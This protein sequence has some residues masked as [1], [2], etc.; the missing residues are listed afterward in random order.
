MEKYSKKFN[1]CNLNERIKRIL[2]N[3]QLKTNKIF[4]DLLLRSLKKI[5]FEKKIS[6]LKLKYKSN[7]EVKIKKVWK[8]TSFSIK[9]KL[10]FN[11]VI[12]ETL[13]TNWNNIQ[14]DKKISGINELKICI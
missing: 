3:K 7:K 13:N 10:L 9:G 1:F 5:K 11:L 2:K 8:N 12:W 14:K 4:I 6:T